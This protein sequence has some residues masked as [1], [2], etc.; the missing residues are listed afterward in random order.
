MEFGPGLLD[1]LPL[2]RQ[3]VEDSQEDCTCFVFGRKMLGVRQLGRNPRILQTL[4]EAR[5]VRLGKQQ[6]RVFLAR[7]AQS[8][9]TSMPPI[10]TVLCPVATEQHAT[11]LASAPMAAVSLNKED[12]DL[13]TVFTWQHI[14]DRHGW[15][16]AVFKDVTHQAHHH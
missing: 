1:I 3:V 2:V 16:V 11:I 7:Q 5:Q 15:G 6:S 4:A 13:G 10:V 9:G 8:A 14:V 12:M